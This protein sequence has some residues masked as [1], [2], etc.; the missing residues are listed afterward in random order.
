MSLRSIL[1]LMTSTNAAGVEI[2]LILIH[3]VLTK[4]QQLQSPQS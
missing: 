4:N 2:K 3:L 1:I